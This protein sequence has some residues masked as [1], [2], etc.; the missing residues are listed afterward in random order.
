MER[1][2]DVLTRTFTDVKFSQAIMSPAC[3][4][5]ADA[6]PFMNMLA[7]ISTT[8]DEASLTSLL[9][10]MEKE[11]NDTPALRSQG[12]VMMDLDLLRYNNHRCHVKDWKRPYIKQLLL[13]L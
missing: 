1:A 12:V 10:N 7:R 8:L 6:P 11:M 5:P 4:M 9:K 2:R 13:S 3:G